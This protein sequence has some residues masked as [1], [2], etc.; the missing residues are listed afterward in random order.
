MLHDLRDAFRALRATPVVTTVAVLS[1]ALGIGANT[2]IFSLVNA[3][4]LRSLPVKDPHELV[5]LLVSPTRTS[6]SNPLWEQIRER[7][8][9]LFSG[10]VAFTQQR[11]NVARGGEAQLVNGVMASGRF[12][13][14]LGVPAIIGR[15]FTAANDVRSGAGIENRQVTVISYGFWQRHY[16]GAADVIGQSIELDRVPFTIIGVT[17]PA[18]TGVDQGTSYDVAVPLATEALM[19][20]AGESMM[21]QRQSWWMRVMARLKPGDTIDRATAA[22]RGIQPQLRDATL[23]QTTRPQAL[24]GYLK[25]PVG[26]RTAANGP[27]GLGRQYKDPLY[28]ILT[29]VRWYC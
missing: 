21:D 15:T 1:L 7:E 13:E 14:V 19:R 28:L 27:N 16:G 11:Y 3:L 5:Q 6:W 29:V 17:P 10:A 8:T 20:G 26:L 9:Q 12:F 23:P 25:D 22:F 18:F 4:M 2:A 24:A